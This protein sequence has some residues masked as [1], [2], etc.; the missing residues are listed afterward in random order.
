MRDKKGNRLKNQS[1]TKNPI[2]HSANVLKIVDGYP[3]FFHY[4]SLSDKAPWL[5]KTYFSATI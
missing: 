5:K 4:E 2:S 3:D 1:F